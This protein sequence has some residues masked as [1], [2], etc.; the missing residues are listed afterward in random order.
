MVK[1]TTSTWQPTF[2]LFLLFK[3]FLA[4]LMK[5]HY[6]A[7]PFVLTLTPTVPSAYYSSATMELHYF[8]SVPS[9]KF[10]ETLL[11]STAKMSPWVFILSLFRS[12]LKTNNCF[13]VSVSTHELYPQFAKIT[14]HLD[15]PLKL[16]WVT[17][18]LW[19]SLFLHI[20]NLQREVPFNL[21]FTVYN[22][23]Q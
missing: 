22:I 12:A 18:V 9:M 11:K 20:R 6:L 16:Q 3:L 4:P 1:S 7:I 15:H 21:H 10:V 2:Q 8:S 5:Q 17:D 13:L 23:H 19:K 14:L